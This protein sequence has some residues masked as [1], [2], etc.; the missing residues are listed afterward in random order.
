MNLGISMTCGGDSW[1]M[2]TSIDNILCG[3]PTKFYEKLHVQLY[4]THAHDE[5]FSQSSLMKEI[6]RSAEISLRDEVFL[7][8]SM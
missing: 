6:I 8:A 5:V 2:E 3:I 7:C 4:K 1:P